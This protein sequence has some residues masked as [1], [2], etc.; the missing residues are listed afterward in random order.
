MGKRSK[1]RAAQ[2]ASATLENQSPS[3]NHIG[4]T[5][6][7]L[8]LS[9]ILIGGL[10]LR[11]LYIHAIRND[12]LAKVLVIDAQFYD[13]WARRILQGDWF[14][15]EIFYQD[16]LYA[17]FLALCYKI[18][19]HDPGRVRVVQALLDTV[20]LALLYDIGMVLFGP[21]VGIVAAGI[22]AFYGPLVYYTGLLDK[23]TFSFFLITLSLALFSRAYRR[24]LGWSLWAGVTMG[25]AAL[26]RGNLLIAAVCMG[27]LL[28]R[29]KAPTRDRLRRGLA[30]TFGV[31]AVV[32]AVT[33]RNFVVGKDLVLLSSNAGLNFLI[34]NN[35]YTVGDYIEPPFLRE[36]PEFSFVDSKD[37]A[38]R[39]PGART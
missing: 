17:Y 23:T 18:F 3:A 7:A 37:Y 24:Q 16:P 21:V 5:W 4:R 35:P 11:L 30:F 19:G 6:A 9:L 33:L 10:V 15:H 2:K 36:I 29:K 27:A 20:S 32:G 31:A 8:L 1:S 13:S 25:L 28:F 22:A 12:A 39:S 26:A 14:G 34:G 38:E